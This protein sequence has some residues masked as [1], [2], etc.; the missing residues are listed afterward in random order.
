MAPYTFE[1]DDRNVEHVSRHGFVPDEVEEV[2]AGGYKTRRSLGALYLAL[3][4]TFAGR[5]TVVVYR[6]LPQRGIQVITARD[7]TKQERRL[8]RRK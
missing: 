1:W 5:Y 4:K 8:F 6:R 2:F 3:G 7:M